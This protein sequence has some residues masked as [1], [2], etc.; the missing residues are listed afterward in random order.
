MQGSPTSDISGQK[1]KRSWDSQSCSMSR[2]PQRPQQYQHRRSGFFYNRFLDRFSWFQVCY[3]VLSTATTNV[4]D[5][6][7]CSKRFKSA[8][9]SNCF[10]LT[11]F[12]NQH[13]VVSGEGEKSWV[14]EQLFKPHKWENLNLNSSYSHFY[15][16]PYFPHPNLVKA[17]EPSP[18]SASCRPRKTMIANQRR[19]TS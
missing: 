8:L 17:N 2:L 15:S 4:P 1:Q 9:T 7:L 19:R 3:H 10:V 14:R 6:T 16:H 12:S 5:P 11:A 18:P 13:C